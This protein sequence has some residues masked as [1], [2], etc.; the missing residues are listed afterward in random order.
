[1]Y[2][3]EKADKPGILEQKLNK[4]KI[5]DNKILLP[6]KEG[7]ITEKKQI[8]L[9]E[10]VNKML[11]KAYSKKLVISKEI[12]KYEVLV[13]KLYSNDY[14]IVDGKKLFEALSCITLEYICKH[15]KINSQE[16]KLSVLVNDLSDYSLQN[17][18]ELSTKYKTLN[19]VTN[20]LEK[21]KKLEDI[22]YNESG[23]MITVSNNKKK[24]LL[25]SDIILNIDFPQELL[26]QFNI[27]DEA[28]IV[29][30]NGNVKINRKRFNGLVINDY[31][32]VINNQLNQEFISDKYNTKEIYEA[33]IYDGIP[34][35]DLM[36]KIKVDKVEISALYGL[37]GKV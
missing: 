28:I 27:K 36:K 23:L 16:T 7:I 18:R 35:I 2:Y 21:F 4:V 37:N 10:K 12:K 9:A 34:Y 13:N 32:I 22:I 11:Q 26:N 6:I 14:I 5:I 24:S 25:Q 30:I 17:I 15:R 29:N 8:K 1:M 3:I 20:H 33:Q 19:I 31:E